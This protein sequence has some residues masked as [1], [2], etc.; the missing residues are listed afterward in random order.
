VLQQLRETV[1]RI[2]SKYDGQPKIGLILGSGLGA[3]ADTFK[4]PTVIPFTELPHFPRPGVAGHPGN[5]VLGEAEGVTVAALQG[6]V[7][8]YEGYSLAEVT[9]PTRVLGYLGIS[10]VI[11]TNAAGGINTSFRPGNLMVISD[12]INLMGANPL[13]G[14][15]V[16]ELGER[17]PDMSEAYDRRMRETALRTAAQKGIPLRQGIYVGLSGPSYETPAEIRMCRTLGADAVGMSTVPEVIVANQMGVR[18]MGISCI[19]NMAAGILPQRLTHREVIE[20][21]ERVKE[22]FVELLRA[23]IPQLPALAHQGEIPS[24]A[25]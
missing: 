5:L 23:V 6:R 15:N 1:A 21:T 11:V 22:Q 4:V 8:F 13:V 20:T 3:F 7:H 12:H 16:D 18:V 24:E 14:A 19:T 10:Q 2:R 17:F 9:Y 25:R